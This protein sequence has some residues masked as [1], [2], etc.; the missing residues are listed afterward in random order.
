LEYLLFNS[1]LVLYIRKEHA[2]GLFFMI[3]E[4]YQQVD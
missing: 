3:L 1:P 2:K 4:L